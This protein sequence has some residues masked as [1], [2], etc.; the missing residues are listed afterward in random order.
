MHV[1]RLEKKERKKIDTHIA[2]CAQSMEVWTHGLCS[3][4][5]GLHKSILCVQHL[6]F[7]TVAKASVGSEQVQEDLSSSPQAEGNVG[8]VDI[9]FYSLDL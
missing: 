4:I 9:M 7:T 1:H 2:T 8:F 5:H 3:A 6:H